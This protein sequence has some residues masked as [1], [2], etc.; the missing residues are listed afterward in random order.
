[1]TATAARVPRLADAVL[2]ACGRYRYRLDRIV[3]DTLL[4]PGF[5]GTVVCYAGVNPSTADAEAEDAT[6]RKWRGFAQRLGAWRYIAI[7]PFA[8]RARDVRELGR[9]DDP[10]GPD[11]DAY[12]DAAIA[13]ADVLVPC[14]GDRG[15]V[16]AP[17][18]PRL[19][20]LLDRMRVS[21]KPV[22]VFG[23]T[24]GGD[25]LHPLMLGYDTLLI[26]L[27]HRSIADER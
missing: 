17:L 11:N 18:R 4:L 20:A 8:L 25:P 26:P 3:N 7:N 16:P 14:W 12:I 1:M 5:D 24:R 13:E 21:G 2:S 6:T 22:L 27:P 23:L 10:V 9:A 19:D 15:K